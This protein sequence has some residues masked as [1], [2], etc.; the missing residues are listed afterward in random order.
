MGLSRAAVLQSLAFQIQT[1]EAG[2]RPSDRPPLPLGITGLDRLFPEGGLPAG[3]LVE[4]FTDEAGAGA[5]TLAVIMARQVVAASKRTL[6]ILD[7]LRT[8]YPPAAARLG[9]DLERTLI[10][11]P[12]ERHVL[13][14]ISQSLRCPA[15]GAV[16]AQCPVLPS[17]AFRQF[18]LAAES[19]GGVGLLLRPGTELRSPSFARLRL[20]VSPTASGWHGWACAT[21]V[22]AVSA[23]KTPVDHTARRAVAHEQASAR[24]IQLE[25][26]RC[27][28]GKE[29]QRWLLEIDDE[30]HLVHLLPEVA[31]AK[32]PARLGEPAVAGL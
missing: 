30:T 24:R 11:R 27:R 5:C 7:P 18:Q 6:V 8:F 15:V 13:S 28:G 20:R 12:K 31:V 14:V 1:I 19:G 3:S 25:V 29:G 17:R 9:V 4:L 23:P 10:V 22:S 32:T 21:A 2:Q 26:I 16:L